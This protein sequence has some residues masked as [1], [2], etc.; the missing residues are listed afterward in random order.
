M[1]DLERR[2]GLGD[3]VA[4]YLETL[5]YELDGDGEGLW[6]IVPA[7]KSFRFEGADLV[8]FVRRCVLRLLDV[9]AVPVRHA[10]DGPLLWQEQTQYGQSN[11]EIADA[12]VAE[13]LAAG[14]GDPPWG[15]LWF[16]NRDV[17]NSARRPQSKQTS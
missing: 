16:V 12:I 14:G 1:I 7:G 2:S 10:K 11:E 6:A 17:L 3:T 9:G 15:W 5:P 8:E 4:E 13:W